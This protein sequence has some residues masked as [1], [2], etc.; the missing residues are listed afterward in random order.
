MGGPRPAPSRGISPKKGHLSCTEKE[1]RS[2][3]EKEKGKGSQWQFSGRHRQTDTE[4]P[5]RLQAVAWPLSGVQQHPK[6]VL[7]G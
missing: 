1:R 6:V 5:D 2:K 7:W 4:P 3:R